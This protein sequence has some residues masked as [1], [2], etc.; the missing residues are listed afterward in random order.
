MVRLV[1]LGFAFS[2]PTLWAQAP[3]KNPLL[4]KLEA[5]KISGPFT[6]L[7]SFRVKAGQEK[8]LMELAKPCVEATRKEKGCIAYDLQ[9]DLDDPTKFILYERWKSPTALEEHMA[10]EHTKKLL[11]S[12]GALMDGPASVRLFVFAEDR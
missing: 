10:E 7:V 8:A 12:W 9:Q 1:L 5:K 3:P 6:L 4:A 2:L 11:A